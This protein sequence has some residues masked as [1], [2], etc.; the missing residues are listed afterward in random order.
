MSMKT[1][2]TKPVSNNPM[3][4]NLFRKRPPWKQTAI[5]LLQET[6]IFEGLP[7]R[8][9]AQLV[10]SMHRRVYR[11]QEAVFRNGD[12]GLGMYLVLSGQVVVS[13][14]SQELARLLPG[15]FFGEVALFGEQHR[16]ADAFASGDTELIGF[17]RPDLEEWVERSP[18]QGS[19][20]LSR[21]GKVLAQRLRASNERLSDQSL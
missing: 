7:R 13:V 4:A 14:N 21:L 17:F 10:D 1:N 15:D 12:E 3:W 11:D 8:V 20:V 19:R 9:V 2:D 5:R 18:K 6:P 16:T